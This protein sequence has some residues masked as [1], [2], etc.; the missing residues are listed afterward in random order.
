VLAGTIVIC[1]LFAWYALRPK[2]WNR[3]SLTSAITSQA[4]D[5]ATERGLATGMQ[6]ISIT[7]LAPIGTVKINN[8]QIEATS[9][10][11]IINPAQ[12][13]EIV[14]LDGAKVIVKLKIES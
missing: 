2:T 6:G 8:V 12:P 3:L 5:T 1:I 4:V 13:V 11:G 14:K 9:F 7:R 10:E